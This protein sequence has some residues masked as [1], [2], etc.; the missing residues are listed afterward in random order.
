VNIGCGANDKN[1][2]GYWF[3]DARYFKGYQYM[4]PQKKSMFFLRAPS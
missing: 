4:K 3:L 1:D 2:T